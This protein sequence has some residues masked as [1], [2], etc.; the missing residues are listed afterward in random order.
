[1]HTD[2]KQPTV[3]ATLGTNVSLM[4]RFWILTDH[5]RRE[6]VLVLRGTMSLNELAV[7][8][9]CDPVEFHVKSSGEPQA[10]EQEELD[11]FN[12]QLES[13]PGSFPLD[14][15]TPPPSPIHGRGRAH[16][17]RPTGGSTFSEVGDSHKAH[18]G[19]LKMARVMGGKGKPVYIAVRHALKQNDGYSEF[20]LVTDFLVSERSAILLDLIICGHSLGAG[21]AGLL[22]LVSAAVE[23]LRL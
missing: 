23:T 19:M 14:L 5:G 11:A 15:S 2:T 3:E 8:L 10:D 13:I 21:V 4:P 9:T 16:S 17:R 22:A 7:D 20:R 12:E 6:V 18:G 1:M